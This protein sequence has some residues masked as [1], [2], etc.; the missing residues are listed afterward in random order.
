MHVN[1]PKITWLLSSLVSLY[2]TV[3]IYIED[4][5]KGIP[6]TELKNIFQ[7]FYH[8]GNNGNIKG[9]GLGLPL[10]NQIIKLHKGQINVHSVPEKAQNLLLLCQLRAVFHKNASVLFDCYFDGCRQ[11]TSI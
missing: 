8:V 6:E 2:S 9:F 5:G 3:I 7:P 10:A 1:I 4:R 11:L